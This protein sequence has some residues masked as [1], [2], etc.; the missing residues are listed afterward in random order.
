MLIIDIQ[1]DP[2]KAVEF[3]Q[4]FDA[5][6]IVGDITHGYFLQKLRLQR[7]CKVLLLGN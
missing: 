5:N 2:I 1:I 6:I 7:A 3:K 4:Q